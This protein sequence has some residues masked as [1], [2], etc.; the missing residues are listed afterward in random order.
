VP[1][2]SHAR[3]AEIVTARERGELA[4]S[5]SHLEASIDWGAKS[6]LCIWLRE[7]RPGPKRQKAP[8]KTHDTRKKAPASK[9]ASREEE[10]G[11]AT[12]ANPQGAAS[13][14]AFTEPA[15]PPLPQRCPLP[16]R[17]RNASGR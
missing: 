11:A 9:K 6:K 3:L 12:D 15:K 16:C 7:R 13:T 5:P 2:P 4:P 8:A 1:A 10:A 17:R 14:R